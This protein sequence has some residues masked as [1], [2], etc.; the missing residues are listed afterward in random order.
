[1]KLLQNFLV[2]SLLFLLII[3]GCGEYDS[4][5]IV[6][7][8]DNG[9]IVDNENERQQTQQV[10]GRMPPPT[11]SSR[12]SSGNTVASAQNATIDDGNDGEKTVNFADSEV[13]VSPVWLESEEFEINGNTRIGVR[14]VT[15]LA[16]TKGTM[17]VLL[18][19]SRW[20]RAEDKI[21]AKF[22]DVVVTIRKNSNTSQWFEP[23]LW[24]NVTSMISIMP[25]ELLEQKDLPL[26]TGEVPPHTIKEGHTFVPY[27]PVE[28]HRHLVSRP[29]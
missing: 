20:V 3:T 15:N 8:V 7:N 27:E 1:M 18:R 13:T 22:D 29:N 16:P 9:L 4:S 11:L 10:V 28:E 26:A 5:L 25:V 21:P 6:D 12:R 19:I 24:P 17:F 23:D 14:V 2:L